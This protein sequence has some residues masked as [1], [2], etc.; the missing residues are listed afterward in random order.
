MPHRPRT[1]TPGT[2]ACV[3][4][5]ALFAFRLLFGLSSEMFF[6]DETQIFLIGLRY[7]ATG[8]W[9]FFGP[10][11]VW[12]KSEIPGALQG[13]LVGVPLR[14]WPIPE[15]PYILLNVLSAA[16]LAAEAWYLCAR[17]PSAPRWLVWGWLFTMPWTLQFSTHIINPSYVLPAAVAFFIGFFETVPAFRRGYINPAAAFAL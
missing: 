9:P 14:V 16:A 17:F 6:E 10:D 15:S 8:H 5:V 4:L 2:A 13:L 1:W 11:V 3:A 7:Y 12:T